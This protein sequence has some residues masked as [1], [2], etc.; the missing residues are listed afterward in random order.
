MRMPRWLRWYVRELQQL[1]QP[2]DDAVLERRGLA[3]AFF[4]CRRAENGFG[5]LKW[6]G[7]AA[8]LALIV[9]WSPLVGLWW[10]GFGLIPIVAHCVARMV[11]TFR[12]GHLV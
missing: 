12:E 2:R 3:R 7:V 4:G 5:A 9:L 10:F 6:G 11:G 1:A 8:P